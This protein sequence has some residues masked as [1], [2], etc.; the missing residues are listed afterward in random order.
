MVK[1]GKAALRHQDINQASGKR[2]QL[3]NFVSVR[4]L[5]HKFLG[6]HTYKQVLLLVQLQSLYLNSGSANDSH[7]AQVLDMTSQEGKQLL[8]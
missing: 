8:E 5:S 2:R 7:I 3:S 4:M 1:D 6:R